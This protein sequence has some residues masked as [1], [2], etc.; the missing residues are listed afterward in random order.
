MPVTKSATSWV[1][2]LVVTCSASAIASARAGYVKP[3]VKVKTKSGEILTV[4]F[5]EKGSQI[6][7]VFL[8]GGAR[9]VFEGKL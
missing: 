6:Q 9:L 3:P 2:V 1:M 5:S 8:E 4:D 7:K